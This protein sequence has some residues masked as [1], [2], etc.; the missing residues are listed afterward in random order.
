MMRAPDT[1]VLQ[2]VLAVARAE[3]PDRLR[4][5]EVDSSTLLREELGLDSGL[6]I[7]LVVALE[8]EFRVDLESADVSEVTTVGDVVGLITTRM[9][10]GR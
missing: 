1:D 2:R 5:V 4:G 6:F 3:V 7:T 10:T 9:D 8:E